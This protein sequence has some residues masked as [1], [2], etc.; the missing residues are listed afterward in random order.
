MSSPNTSMLPIGSMLQGKYRIDAFLAS[1]GFGN[2]YVATHMAL[3]KKVAVKEFFM[4][5]VN[6]REEGSMTVIV[7]NS[8]NKAM[9]DEQRRKFQKEAQRISV[10]NNPHIIRV[11]DLFSENNTFYYV[12]EYIDGESFSIRLK[13]RGYPFDEHTVKNLLVQM[14]DALSAIHK[15]SIWHMDIKP[16][17]ILMD[18]NGKCTLID[19]G[20]SKQ[21]GKGEGATTS[22]AM[23]YTPGYA[24]SEQINGLIEKWGPWTDFYA[25]GATLYNLLTGIRPPLF[26]DILENEQNAFHF[27]DY[28]SQQMRMLIQWMM[29]PK[30]KSRPQ[31]VVAL[32]YFINNNFVD[33]VHR[34]EQ[35]QDEPVV[36]E[37]EPVVEEETLVEEGSVAAFEATKIAEADDD[38]QSTEYSYQ[39]VVVEEQTDDSTDSEE[40]QADNEEKLVDEETKSEEEQADDEVNSEEELAHDAT[41]SDEDH[42][43]LHVAPE[44]PKSKARRFLWI[45]PVAAILA[46]VFFLV[47]GLNKSVTTKPSAPT[48]IKSTVA[49]Q[50]ADKGNVN[51]T[52]DNDKS[53]ASSSETTPAAETSGNL[54]SASDA[55]N[56]SASQTSTAVKETK[57]KA[58]NSE[59]K[60]RP[61]T[62]AGHNER[63]YSQSAR[64]SSANSNTANNAQPRKSTP[65]NNKAQ[66]KT[67]QQTREKP[68]VVVNTSRA[69][70]NNTNLKSKD[71][72]N[73]SPSRKSGSSRTSAKDLLNESPSRNSNS[74]RTSTKDLLN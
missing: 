2:T 5:G 52:T 33:V 67:T 62:T 22:T 46:V 40:E 3:E 16:G 73:E 12:M 58:K 71:L 13:Q 72:L 23:S 45:L 4:K 9:F 57:D 69:G 32:N 31:S 44:K 15:H 49:D 39:Q 27:P 8:D 34:Q 20:S 56:S 66:A 1:G 53:D 7:S 59:T 68:Q 47:K 54:S 14:V 60:E 42:Q 61:T 11:T 19:F 70:N 43:Q 26:D 18:S 48:T 30:A 36:E 65:A 29:N 28:I 64:N 21:S 25:L 50:P 10:L 63:T 24:P 74:S 37:D 6:H 55:D 51:K 38:V 17:N 41:D 35:E